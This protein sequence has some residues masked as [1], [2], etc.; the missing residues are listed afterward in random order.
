MKLSFFRSLRNR[1]WRKSVILIAVGLAMLTASVLVPIYLY[2][3][4]WAY[5]DA[6]FKIKPMGSNTL[7]LGPNLGSITRLM[8]IM[9]GEGVLEFEIEDQAGNTILEASLNAGRYFYELPANTINSYTISLRNSG[10]SQ[11]SIYW[12]VWAF[13]YNTIFQLASM[14]PLIMGIYSF[15][16]SYKEKKVKLAVK[17]NNYF[18]VENT[19][20]PKKQQSLGGSEEIE[21][22]FEKA[23]RLT[24]CNW[25]K[26]KSVRKP[27][28]DSKILNNRNDQVSLI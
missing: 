13:Y 4:T 12:I 22:L 3:P 17:Q 6:S 11:Q 16:I 18:N 8:L 15:L 26:K 7:R 19:L 9:E 10:L 20:A 21:I 2:L 24:N 23:I 27:E 5:W 25:E 28:T 1:H 14:F